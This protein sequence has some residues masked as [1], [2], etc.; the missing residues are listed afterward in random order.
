[1]TKDTPIACSLGENELG[2]RLDAIAKIGANS[3]ISHGVE[4]GLHLLRFRASTA[5]RQSLEG[6]IKA[7]AECCAFLDLSLSEEG[8]ELVLSIAAPED[9]QPLAD[10]FAKAFTG[11]ATSSR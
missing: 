4:G 9:A 10:E 7:E 2:R 8:D 11:A 6:I 3:L 1:M 5:T